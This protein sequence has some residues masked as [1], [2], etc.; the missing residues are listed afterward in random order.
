MSGSIIVACLWGLAANILALLPSKDNYWSR[1]YILMAIGVPVLG[2][3]TY[4]NGP[5][6]G[7][8]VLLAGMWMLRWPVRYLGRWVKR[9]FNGA[10]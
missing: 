4:E 7:L 10:A 3:V 5:W 6:V 1:A 8:A 2:W 9:Q